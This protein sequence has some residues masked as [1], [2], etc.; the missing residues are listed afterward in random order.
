MKQSFF[1]SIFS[2]LIALK[3]SFQVVNE[4]RPELII[5]N[6]PGNETRMYNA[7]QPARFDVDV[8]LSATQEHVCRSAM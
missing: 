5:C 1:T 2:T 6:G 7:A 4:K 8:L 3:D